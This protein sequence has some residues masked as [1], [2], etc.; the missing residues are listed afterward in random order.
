MQR[1]LKVDETTWC[2]CASSQSQSRAILTYG[3]TSCDATRAF[4]QGLCRLFGE[5]STR[6]GSLKEE[7]GVKRERGY[8]IG[9]FAAAVGVA[10]GIVRAV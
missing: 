2:R 9:S 6:Q 8:R 10:H 7:L 5:T 3:L 1:V 4:V